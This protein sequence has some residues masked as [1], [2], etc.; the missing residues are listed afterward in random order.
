VSF[1]LLLR[2]HDLHDLSVNTSLVNERLNTN[3]RKQKERKKERKRENEKK[4]RKKITLLNLLNNY[5]HICHEFFHEHDRVDVWNDVV[6]IES[7]VYHHDVVYFLL[8]N[9]SV[10]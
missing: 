5:H 3:E 8:S 6:V 4:Q 9:F 10:H 1:F 2:C 7:L